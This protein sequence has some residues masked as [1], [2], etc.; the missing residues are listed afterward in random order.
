MNPAR[1][2]LVAPVVAVLGAGNMGAGI[3]Q[4]CAQAG[5][6]VRVRDLTDAM[7]AR[8]RASI[9]KTLDGGVSRGKLTAARRAEVL[10]RISFTTELGPAV[11]G[12]SLVIEAVFE[13]ESVKR[14]LFDDVA[15]F[16]APE[17]LVATNTSS[18]SVGHLAEGFPHPERFAGLHFFYPAPINKLL[19]VVGGPKTSSE[20]LDALT[21]IGYRLRKTPIRVRDSAGFAINRFF[22]PYLNEAARLLGENAASAATIEAAGRELTG[23]TLGPF[24]LMNVTGTTIAFH[25]MGS[26]GAAFGAPY[27]PAA[28]LEEQFRLGQP[29]DW[30]SGEVDRAAIPVVRARLEGL[31]FGIAAQLVDEGVARAE[32]VEVGACVGLRWKNGPFALMGELGLPT[33]LA[34]VEAYAK[35]WGAAF[36]VA[37]GLAARA[38]AGERSWPLSYVRVERRGAVTWVLLDRPQVL[39]SLS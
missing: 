6:E 29:W 2:P 36:P 33:A 24:E 4:A 10:E 13:E 21:A 20:T 18:L 26:L 39:N 5:F 27:A 25:S 3:A 35:P 23:A 32:D 22:V 1:S 12:A 9:E 8:G 16:V 31:I 17:T 30:K 19:E 11:Q 37:P 38:H 28:R 15:G 14:Q 7:L 34:R